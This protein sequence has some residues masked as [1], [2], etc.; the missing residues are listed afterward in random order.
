MCRASHT[1]MRQDFAALATERGW[2][3]EEIE[4][5]V[6]WMDARKAKRLAEAA[7]AAA[8]TAE[9]TA[10]ATA[11]ADLAIRRAALEKRER[12]Q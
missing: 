10:I 8:I 3:E 4:K 1:I 12:V 5:A 11:E 2:T 9:R 7:E 6:A